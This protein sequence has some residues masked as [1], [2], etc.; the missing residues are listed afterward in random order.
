MVLKTAGLTPVLL[1]DVARV[2]LGPDERRGVAELKGEGEVVSS[3]GLQ[4]Y[5]QNALDVIA[6]PR[7]RRS[8][9]QHTRTAVYR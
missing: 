3:I 4:R 5:G 6:S 9:L 7:S 1:R 8:R 2:G